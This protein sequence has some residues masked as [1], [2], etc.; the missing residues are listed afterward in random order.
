MINVHYANRIRNPITTSFLN[1]DTPSSFGRISILLL[2]IVKRIRLSD[3]TRRY[4]RN[5][6][7]KLPFAELFDNDH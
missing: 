6:I 3:L 1:A 7:D 5:I 2:H 4:Y